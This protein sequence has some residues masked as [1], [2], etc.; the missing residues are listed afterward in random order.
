MKKS[1]FC[2]SEIVSILKEAESGIRVDDVSRKSRINS[3]E[4]SDWKSKCGG[5]EASDL[6][7]VKELESE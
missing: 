2:E 3:A 5:I 6:M 7:K 4:H 1:R